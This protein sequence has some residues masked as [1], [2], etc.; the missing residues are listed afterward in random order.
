MSN[1]QEIDK[2]LQQILGLSPYHI[3]NHQEFKIGFVGLADES[4]IDTLSPEVNCNNLK[5]TNYNE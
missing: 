3:L 1:F 4:W 2:D 5:Y